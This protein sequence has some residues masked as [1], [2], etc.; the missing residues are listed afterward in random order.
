MIRM[1][2][3]MLTVTLTATHAHRHILSLSVSVARFLRRSRSLTAAILAPQ[4]NYLGHFLL[5]NQL[6]PLLRA[7]PAPRVVSVASVAS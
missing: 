2:T 6:M 3:V 7:A 4:V 5:T 1:L